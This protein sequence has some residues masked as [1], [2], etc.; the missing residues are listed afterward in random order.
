MSEN[1]EL[2]QGEAPLLTFRIK[3]KLP[4]GSTI[5]FDLTGATAIAFK[6]KIDNDV[7][8]DL[9]SY[10]MAGG[11]IVVTVVGTEPGATYSE[12]TVQTKSVDMTTPQSLYYRLD[13]TKNA[14]VTSVKHGFLVVQ[15]A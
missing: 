2:L 14:R 3:K 13:V 6:A 11:D 5:P 9:F 4:D 1:I 10:T 15:N 8:T 7:D 12:V